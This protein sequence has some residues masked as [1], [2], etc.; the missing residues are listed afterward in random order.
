M[1]QL[2][3]F[4]QKYKY[5]LYLLF[6]LL[7]ALG[8]TINNH[9]F[10]RSKFIS[11]TNSITGGIYEKMS[12]LD[13]YLNLKNQNKALIKENEL[14]RN[15]LSKL[16]DTITKNTKKDSFNYQQRYNYI[17]GKILKNEFHKSY[18]YLTINKGDKNGVSSE[19]A[20]VN[21]KGIVG[22]TDNTSEKYARVQSILNRNSKI[23]ARFKNSFHFGTLTWNTKDYNTV[24]LID[25]PRQAV[26]NIG[27]TII[28]GGR[29]AIFPEGIPVGT[30]ISKST[31]NSIDIK[32]F[33]DMSNLG[34]I[35]IIK[36]FHKE[37]IQ[38]LEKQ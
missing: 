4:F 34:S 19:M 1:Q 31:S 5:G 24:Q 32:L 30:V 26:F 21:F 15:K 13:T 6:L 37:E 7:I 9:N 33:N 23:N 8:L 2:I 20:V 38:N 18:N 10:H 16:T 35:Y 29:S 12:G 27:D 17:S 14:L 36:N 11:S 3:Y 28:T 25:I 22:I